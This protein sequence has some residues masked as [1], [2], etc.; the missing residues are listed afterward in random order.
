[1]AQI[2]ELRSYHGASPDAGVDVLDSQMLLGGKDIDFSNTPA[3]DALTIPLAGRETRYTFI[4]NLRFFT[5]DP[6]EYWIGNIQLYFARKPADWRG[7]E[8]FVTT[9]ATYVDPVAQGVTPL[10]GFTHNINTIV[11]ASPL[12]I[13]GYFYDPDEGAI[14]D[15][16]IIQAAITE[17][18]EP[19]ILESLGVFANWTEWSQI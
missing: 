15:Y 6:P 14:G 9:S 18:A 8:V 16:I 1:M 19:G 3:V 12:E 2:L 7:V 5:N 11:E 10:T 4:K 17:D 13:D